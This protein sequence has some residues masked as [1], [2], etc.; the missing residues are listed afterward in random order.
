[1]N[2]HQ[3]VHE[4]FMDILE[5]QMRQMRVHELILFMNSHFVHKRS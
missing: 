5:Q 3:R 1:M 4:R 2:V